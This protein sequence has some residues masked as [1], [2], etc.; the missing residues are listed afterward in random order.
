RNKISHELWRPGAVKLHNQV[1]QQA[2]EKIVPMLVQHRIDV[3][4]THLK[5]LS[6]IRQA[7]LK[8]LSEVIQ[9]KK[10]TPDLARKLV[11]DSLRAEKMLH[12]T[13]K[14]KDNVPPEGEAEQR[15]RA[16]DAFMREMG[17]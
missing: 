10:L 14:E 3:L 9:Q 15:K 6:G 7:S 12:D 8:Y 11:F 5:F 1:E 13:I 4:E 2:N 16:F 17:L